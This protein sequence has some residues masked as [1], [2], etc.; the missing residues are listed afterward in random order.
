MRDKR[1]ALY[2]DVPWLEDSGH[3]LTQLFSC[4]SPHEL[5]LDHLDSSVYQVP[6]ALQ[7]AVLLHKLNCPITNSCHQT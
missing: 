4:P 3:K 5:Y 6:I 1:V 7:E 2:E